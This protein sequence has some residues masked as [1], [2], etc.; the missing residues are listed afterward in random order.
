VALAQGELA[1]NFGIQGQYISKFPTKKYA[2]HCLDFPVVTV[3]PENPYRVELDHTAEMKC[4]VDA[5]PR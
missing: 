2:I 3:G 1:E 5:R 4:K